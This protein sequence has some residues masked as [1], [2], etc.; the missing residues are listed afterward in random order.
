MPTFLATHKWKQEDDSA[1]R[2]ELL[3]SANAMV[4]GKFPE[5]VKLC[6]AYILP[7]L[8]SSEAYGIWEAPSREAFD[9]GLNTLAPTMKKNTQVIQVMQ[10][11]PPS[12]EYVMALQRIAMATVK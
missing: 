6:S 12:M 5:G 1:V 2:N 10:V 7:T 9:K 3:A 8:P 11:Y 4:A